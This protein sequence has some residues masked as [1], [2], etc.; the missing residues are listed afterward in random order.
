[1]VLD[2]DIDKRMATELR[3]RGRNVISVYTLGLSKEKDPELLPKLAVMFPGDDWVLFTADDR[4]PFEHAD[5]VAKSGHAI[6][7]IDPRRT[8]GYTRTLEWRRE[9][10]HRWV[11]MAQGQQRGLIR[12]YSLNS[13]RAWRAR[14]HYRMPFAA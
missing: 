1:L 4:M 7:T 13:H 9:I 5:A 8:D 2:A 6:A 12:R 11:H 3:K 10:V 14:K